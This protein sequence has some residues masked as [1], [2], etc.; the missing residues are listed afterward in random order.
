MRSRKQGIHKKPKRRRNRSAKYFNVPIYVVVVFLVGLLLLSV[1]SV[2]FSLNSSKRI[3]YSYQPIKGALG[4]LSTPVKKATLFPTGFA[5]RISVVPAGIVVPTVTPEPKK[6]QNIVPIARAEENKAGDFCLN[7]PVLLYHHIEPLVIAQQLGHAQLTVDSDYFDQQMAYLNTSGYHSLS[8]DE[9]ADALI[10]H[11]GLPAKSILITLD[12]GYGDNYNYAFQI[13]KKY[14]IAGNFMIPTG[15]VENKGYMTW[16]Q[17]KEMSGNPLMHIYNHTWSHA[18]LDGAGK[19]KIEYEITTANNQ[20]ESNLV[21]QVKIFTYPFG[22]FN[23]LVIG[24]LREHG[25]SAAFSTINGSM[26]C[27]SYIFA[28]RRTHIGNAPL[29]SY[30]F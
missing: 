1:C 7:V 26:Q 16:N 2:Y 22:S 29:P 20:L 28:L 30:G 9:L 13:L 25:F 12:D 24:V 27:E 18:S 17:L 14:N 21:K 5:L 8:A 3:N 15:L 4:F 19:D 10:G 11:H 23:D 6:A